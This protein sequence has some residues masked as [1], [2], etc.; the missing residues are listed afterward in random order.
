MKKKG[1]TLIELLS[2]IVVLGIVSAITIPIIT[3]VINESSM[4][5]FRDTAL[6]VVNTAKQTYVDYAGNEMRVNMSDF[7][8]YLDGQSTGTKM[9]YNGAAPKSGYVEI[10]ADGEVKL[11]VSD[12]KYCAYKISNTEQVQVIKIETTSECTE[13]NL[14]K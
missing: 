4:K 13:A 6:G 9:I 2:V 7:I 8:I 11:I 10:D 12:G 14:K 5:A 1:F 3:D